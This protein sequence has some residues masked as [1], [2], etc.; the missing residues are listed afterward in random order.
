MGVGKGKG[1]MI[2]ADYTGPGNNGAKFCTSCELKVYGGLLRLTGEKSRPEPARRVARWGGTARDP[3]NDALIGCGGGPRPNV[4]ARG[5]EAKLRWSGEEFPESLPSSWSSTWHVVQ[6]INFSLV[7]A[8]RKSIGSRLTDK[9]PASQQQ[10][11]ILSKSEVSEQ[12][13]ALNLE[14]ILFVHKLRQ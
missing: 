13:K 9:L 8:V 7:I 5:V 3:S 11:H 4:L 2:L 12:P 10:S 1:I 6:P 14:A